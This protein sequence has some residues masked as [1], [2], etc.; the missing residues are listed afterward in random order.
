MFLIPYLAIHSQGNLAM[1]QSP[2]GKWMNLDSD[3]L[4]EI[5]QNPPL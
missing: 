4:T 3:L 5:L 2:N 1:E